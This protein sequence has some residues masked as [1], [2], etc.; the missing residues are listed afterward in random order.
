MRRQV[1]QPF[2][3]AIVGLSLLLLSGCVARV[4]YK[5][6][7]APQLAGAPSW[8]TPLAGGAVAKPGDD[9]TLSRWWATLG[10]DALTLLEERAVR[11][12]LD[13]RK[14]EARIREARAQRGV[15]QT[16]RLPTVTAGGSAMG[17]RSSTRDGGQLSQS[18]SAA[19]DASW[20]PDFFGRIRGTIEAYDADLNAAQ[21]DLRSVLVSLTAEVALSYVD[22]RS[23]QSQLAITRANLVTQ[24]KTYELT[25]VRYDS[26]LATELDAQQAKLTVESTRAG[27]P[28]LEIG[29]QRA[30][31]NIAVLLGERPGA[32]DAE[33]AVVKPVPVVPAQIAVGVPA[34]LLRRRPDIRASERQVA[35]QTARL[36]VATMD[37][38]PTFKLSGTLGVNSATILNL[39]T[40]ATLVSS[41]A[42][43]FQQT[44]F[45]REKIRQQIKVQDAVL[46]QNL[47]AYESTVLLAM[48]DVEDALNAFAK[49]QVRRKSLADAS[50]AAGRAEGMSRGLYVAGLK[51]FLTVL[52]AQRSLLTLQNQLA[53]SDATITADLIRLY[54]AL[55]GGWQ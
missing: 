50:E 43:S 26:G 31:N 21:E 19:L 17:S 53:Q 45:N 10:D 13:L 16:Q 12:N 8:N 3:A 11:G 39:L 25:L 23:Y 44:I 15:I 46:D 4:H 32:V 49:E 1:I 33:L 27:I 48:Q 42:G 55:G 22:V 30:A 38:N 24:Q 14:A 5:P 52:D 29:L 34:E 28:S 9:E 20:E 47:A 18:Y 41:L 6:P 7:V 54:K 51:D 35:A 36:G 2:S 37:L 40:P